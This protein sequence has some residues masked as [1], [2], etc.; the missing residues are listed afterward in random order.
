MKTKGYNVK[1]FDYPAGWVRHEQVSTERKRLA[2]WR[3]EAQVRAS[4]CVKHLDAER[5]R[6]KHYVYYYELPAD[7][8]GI[9]DVHIYYRPYE[10][11]DEQFYRFV[12]ECKPDYVGAIHIHS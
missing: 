11:T 5:K 4:E 2:E 3:R 12:D 10:T 8:M 1:I 7:E 6:G 9:V